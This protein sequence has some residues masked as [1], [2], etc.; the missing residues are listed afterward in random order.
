MIAS[1]KYPS[2]LPAQDKDVEEMKSNCQQCP[3]PDPYK[4]NTAKVRASIKREALI[5]LDN[6][7][8]NHSGEVNGG[9]PQRSQFEEDTSNAAVT[10][11]NEVDINHYDINPNNKNTNNILL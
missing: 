7:R 9:D 8:A 2:Q 6:G 11:E 4:L 10:G 1:N 3:S 5:A